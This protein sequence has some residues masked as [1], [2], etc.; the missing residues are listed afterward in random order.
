M[1]TPLEEAASSLQRMQQFDTASLPR[2]GEL[3]STLSFQDAVAPAQKISD[4][5]NQ[6]SIQTLPWFGERQLDQLQSY[7]WVLSTGAIVLQDPKSFD[8][9]GMAIA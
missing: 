5:Y 7:C 4:L 6:L 1:A 2:V 8:D 3:R 9:R